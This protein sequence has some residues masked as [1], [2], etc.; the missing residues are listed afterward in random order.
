M[1]WGCSD[2]AGGGTEGGNVDM[3]AM[4]KSDGGTV[5]NAR[6]YLIPV[7]YNPNDTSEL[8]LRDTLADERGKFVFKD[9]DTG[10]YTLRIASSDEAEGVLASV[11]ITAADTIEKSFTIEP[12]GAV[13]LLLDT[14]IDTTKKFCYVPNT[15]ITLPLSNAE[16]DESGRYLKLTYRALPPG[17]LDTLRI[18]NS[19][20]QSAEEV[21]A[22]NVTVTSGKEETVGDT[23]HW[24]PLNKSG[25]LLDPTT[26]VHTMTLLGDTLWFA[27]HK[28][29]YTY[30]PNKKIWGEKGASVATKFNDVV[31]SPNN[32]ILIGTATGAFEL[33]DGEPP[34]K[35]S[36]VGSNPVYT[37]LVE[38]SGQI[39]FALGSNG[40]VAVNGDEI[41]FITQTDLANEEIVD[42]V[43]TKSGTILFRSVTGKLFV[44]SGD[45]YTILPLKVQY[46]SKI[47]HGAGDVLY[48]LANETVFETTESDLLSGTMFPLDLGDQI[49]DIAFD[50]ASGKLF[51]TT[52]DSR[53]LIQYK[54][55]IENTILFEDQISGDDCRL[56]VNSGEGFLYTHEDLASFT[57]MY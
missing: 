21:V 33:I 56:I 34:L 27:T 16:L 37:I 3:V 47:I 18:W 20:N 40:V 19:A 9:V 38:Q 51:A 29:L 12:V 15:N 24:V 53:K 25:K 55:T 36:S 32:N 1:V 6:V 31:R 5:A 30:V 45:D 46:V 43:Q 4:V 54:Q 50:A 57:Y 2:T 14:S 23:F 52:D 35:Y 41:S 44:K 42:I 8:T 7:G 26:R 28:G 11:I 39:W 17:V 10:T 22:E 48:V 49:E 13:T